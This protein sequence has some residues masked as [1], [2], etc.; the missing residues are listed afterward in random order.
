M[1]WNTADIHSFFSK[2]VES[3]TNDCI[4]ATKLKK[5]STFIKRN[6]SLQKKNDGNV[7]WYNCYATYQIFF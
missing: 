2:F 4:V 3:R 5:L 6:E 1:W 7:K